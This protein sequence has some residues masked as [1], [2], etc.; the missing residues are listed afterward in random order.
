MVNCFE[1]S[2]DQ[3]ETHMDE[4]VQTIIDSLESYYLTLPKGPG[5]ITYERF[6]EAY[7]VLVKL[8]DG[9][10]NF[11]YDSV[12]NTFSE[13]NLVFVVMRTI[14]G[15]SPPEWADLTREK[16]HVIVSQGQ[17]RKFDRDVREQKNK[18]FSVKAQE[19]LSAM[20]RTAILVISQETHNVPNGIIHRFDKVDTKNGIQSIRHVD[21]MGIPYPMLLY[22]R[23]LGRPF[24]S[25]RDAVSE[26]IGDIMEIAV[27]KELEKYRIPYRKTTRAEKVEGFDQVP[28]FFIPDEYRPKVV[29]EAKIT[30]DDGTARDKVTRIQHLH[31]ISRNW[32]EEGKN[33]FQVI[34]CIDGRGFSIRKS[35]IIKLIEHTEGK[36][37]T[38]KTLPKLV[39]HSKLKE[40]KT[41]GD[42]E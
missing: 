9:F 7:D 19:K 22:E 33:P 39:N 27:E 15:L 28:D 32:Q 26:M 25:H 2:E 21:R 36:V 29:I 34:A 42:K 14:L 41:R 6:G 18:E 17:A 37:F 12:W 8:T 13:D 4:L 35:D 20:L 3:L 40:Y 16:T 38:M 24:A 5:Y 1:I 10:D 11:S 31:T 23:F 30:Q